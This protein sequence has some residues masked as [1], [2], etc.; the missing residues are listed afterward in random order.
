M[1]TYVLSAVGTAVGGPVGG[2]VGSMIGAM[3][4]R[5]IVAAL[6]PDTKITQTGPRLTEV[7][8]MA[9]TEGAIVPKVYGRARVGGQVIW[10]SDFKEVAETTTTEVSS[11][12]KGGA[13]DRPP[14]PP[15]STSTTPRSRSRSAPATRWPRS[16]TSGS[17]SNRADIAKYTIR[18]YP[19]SQTQSPDP[20]IQAM[21]GADN[22]P[23]YRGTA[24]AVFEEFPLEEFGN[25]MPQVTAEIVVPLETPDPDDLGNAGRAWQLIPGSGE[26]ALGAQVYTLREGYFETD[27]DFIETD[28]KLENVHNSLRQPDYVVSVDQL[29]AEQPNARRGVAGGDLVRHRP[30]RRAVPDRPQGRGLGAHHG[31]ERLAGGG[32]RPRRRRAR[33]RAPTTGRTSAARRRTRRCARRSATCAPRASG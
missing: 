1:A 23:A 22:T 16:A 15:R 11:G 33:C 32:H 10:C 27:G 26:V 7:A 8:I 14:R 19:G 9:S 17:T 21:E 29:M 30:A 5:Q 31:P 13:G 4:D 12:G 20:L 6:T 2:F 18:F 25:R 24:Y 3:I 28:R